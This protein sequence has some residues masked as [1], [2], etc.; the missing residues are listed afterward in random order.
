MAHITVS[1]LPFGVD[2]LSSRAPQAQSCPPAPGSR[3]ST[4]FTQEVN[5]PWY[6]AP[7]PNSE[8]F[9]SYTSREYCSTAKVKRCLMLR[10]TLE[11]PHSGDAANK[12]GVPD[13]VLFWPKDG[14]CIRWHNPP[15]NGRC[16]SSFGDNGTTASVSCY[17]GLV[18]LSQY[19]GLGK[20][21]IFTLDNSNLD[22]PYSIITRAESLNDN[23]GLDFDWEPRDTQCLPK[24]RVKWINCRWPRF[25][26]S[27]KST[28]GSN[29]A[30]VSQWFVHN[31][32][33]IQQ[34][35][36]KNLDGEKKPPIARVR[37]Q[38]NQLIR[39]S[40]Y[41]DSKHVFNACREGSDD[42]AT[43]Y[44]YMSAPQGYGWVTQHYL[45]PQMV[46]SDPKLSDTLPSSV[47][48]IRTVFIN[49]EAW[50]EEEQSDRCLQGEQKHD[51]VLEKKI[52]HKE[53]ESLEIIMATKLIALPD[54]PVDW[55]NFIISAREANVNQLLQEETHRLW[56]RLE[57][58]SISLC[59]LDPP[60]RDFDG[61]HDR[62]SPMGQEG[63][64]DGQQSAKPRR[65]RSMSQ[66][67]PSSFAEAPESPSG[68]P[69][70]A[71]MEYINWR[72]LE[73]I[74]SVCAIPL[75]PPS[76]IEIPKPQGPNVSKR[77]AVVLTC[78]DLSGHRVCTSAS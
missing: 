78:G 65:R 46:T 56:G 59:D 2:Q 10:D 32:T 4:L 38:R 75:S 61:L 19:L 1:C 48:A 31:N 20:S 21:G 13:R 63:V 70:R 64:Q 43:S 50:N 6:D 30:V 58:P 44:T 25:E 67:T 55:R 23:C 74:L 33:V 35:V 72:T 22:E 9:K 41:L 39:E 27:T 52:E 47:A 17:G 26:Y 51:I 18:Q 37:L 53:D 54:R 8:E 76:L 40:N 12:N 7:E 16:S 42:Y 3:S 36:F 71:Y 24:P 11:N 77:V 34:L 69:V 68:P 49:G 73:H 29:V 45:D 62:C 15:E 14:H 60:L 28:S 5:L 57:W 66:V